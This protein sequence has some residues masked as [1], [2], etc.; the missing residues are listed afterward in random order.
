MYLLN[1]RFAPT[2][3]AIGFLEAPLPLVADACLDWLDGNPM[4]VTRSPI[5]D[6]LSESLRRLEPLTRGP[7][8]RLW[9]E[10]RSNWVA[11]FDN[12]LT[13]TD[14]VSPVGH[15]CQTIKCRGV[16]LRCVPHTRRREAPGMKG[17]YGAV[18]FEL[19]RPEPRPGQILNHERSIAVVHDGN[20]WT[21]E[22]WGEVQPFERPE[23]YKARKVIDRFSPA[24]LIEY[25]SA[26]GIHPFDEDFY[27]SHGSLIEVAIPVPAGSPCVSF[28]EAQSS[29]GLNGLC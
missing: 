28:A 13:G 10:T 1:N 26:L 4:P 15:L 19:F 24:M 29:L 7:W 14:P 18:T 23:R 21:F 17:R 6:P 2:T 16:I 27:G 3:F 25:C 20:C 11:Y 22:A 5:E 9:V 8:R 12:I